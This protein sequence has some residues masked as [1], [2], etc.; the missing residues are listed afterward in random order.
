MKGEKRLS[1]HEIAILACKILGVYMIIQGINV[2][3]NVVTATFIMP[4]QSASTM[5][6][7]VIFPFIFLI[8]FG[9]I[10]WFLSGKLSAFMVKGEA[11]SKEDSDIK[12]NDLQRVAFSFLGLL[13]MGTSLPKLI[14]GLMNFIAMKEMIDTTMRLLPGLL[15]NIA[16]LII[17]LGIFFGS[18]GLVNLLEYIRHF[19]LKKEQDC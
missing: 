18:Q 10:L 3:A 14:S 7:N 15:G 6:V 17:G 5:L 11:H 1:K 13:F 19:G 12:A 8:I 16:Q 4:D 2:L 9:I